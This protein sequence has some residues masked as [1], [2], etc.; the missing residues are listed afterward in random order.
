MP[1]ICFLLCLLAGA[2]CSAQQMPQAPPLSNALL[3]S[4]SRAEH[5]FFDRTNLA[6]HGWN[7][8]AETYDAIT[9]RRALSNQPI[10][11]LNPFGAL[12]V[13]HG[14]GGQAV[15]SYGFGVGGPL[16]TSYLLHRTGHHKLERW[17]VAINALGSTTAG[18]WNLSH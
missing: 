5:R 15:F 3:L 9:T 4:A 14:W 17:M 6:L 18:S 7:V 12:F 16:L 1:K 13:N 2:V 8:A 11:E 10:H